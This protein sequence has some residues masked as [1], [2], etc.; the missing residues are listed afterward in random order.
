MQRLLSPRLRV[1]SLVKPF[2]SL[3]TWDPT[4][5]VHGRPAQAPEP[6]EPEATILA[7][8]ATPIPSKKETFSASATDLQA[9]NEQMNRPGSS[10][11]GYLPRPDGTLSRQDRLDLLQFQTY[12]R[13]RLSSMSKRMPPQMGLREKAE[14]SFLEE[15][16]VEDALPRK[17]RSLRNPLKETKQSEIVLTNL[18]LLNR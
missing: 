18:P 3:S 11:G 4:T 2:R 17:K 12:V 10:S 13:E 1:L 14:L 7:D 9:F 16:V 5:S 6:E 8:P 15:Q